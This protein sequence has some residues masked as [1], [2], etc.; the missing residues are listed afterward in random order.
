VETVTLRVNGRPHRLSVRGDEL[1]LDV[2]RDRLG[3][4]S[5]REGCGIGVC[6]ACTVLLDGRPYSACLTL[7]AVVEGRQILTLEGLGTAE[8]LDPLQMA[9]LERTGFQ[10]A[11]CTPGL[12][13]T[14]KALLAE[15]P[16]ATDEE[17]REYLSGNL[18][19]CGS[20]VKIVDSVRAAVA[21]L[22]ARA[23]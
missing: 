11:Y 20:Y 8:Q 10:C 3:L 6:G 1:L 17:L 13:L 14:A 21:G 18:C 9:F 16:D 2:L 7:A 22:T 5:V 23:C 12:I 4:L 15:H 19:R